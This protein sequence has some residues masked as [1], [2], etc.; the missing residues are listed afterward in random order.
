MAPTSAAGPR[1]ATVLSVQPKVAERRRERLFAIL[2]V[3]ADG[4]SM[5]SSFVAEESEYE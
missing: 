3:F 5:R 4:R 2:A 1:G